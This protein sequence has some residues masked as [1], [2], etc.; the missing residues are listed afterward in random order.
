MVYSCTKTAI[1]NE[2]EIFMKMKFHKLYFIFFCIS[3]SNST[4]SEDF[5]FKPSAVKW[6]LGKNYIYGLIFK[7]YFILQTCIS[8]FLAAEVK[9][10]PQF[11]QF[12]KFNSC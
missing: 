12:I 10:S 11:H 3:V 2:T 8:N 6:N 9:V 4:I 1:C 7:Q 5:I